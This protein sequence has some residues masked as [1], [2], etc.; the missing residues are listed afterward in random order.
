VLWLCKQDG[1]REEGRGRGE[2]KK[3]EGT[4]L[5]SVRRQSLSVRLQLT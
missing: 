4:Y 3:K 1:R 2:G 5:D